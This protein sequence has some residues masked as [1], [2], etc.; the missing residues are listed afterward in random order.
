MREKQCLSKGDTSLPP[1]WTQEGDW[2]ILHVGPYVSGCVQCCREG[3]GAGG[4]TSLLTLHQGACGNSKLCPDLKHSRLQWNSVYIYISEICFPRS[5]CESVKP[6]NSFCGTVSTCSPPVQA[7]HL[8]DKVIVT[9]QGKLK[10]APMKKCS[11][12]SSFI[13]QDVIQ[14][15]L[16]SPRF[17]FFS[18]AYT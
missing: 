14:F 2:G 9:E 16:L 17:L 11:R 4:P 6:H 8:S 12:I 15:K 18:A 13:L 3:K 5:T 10:H 7:T 1:S